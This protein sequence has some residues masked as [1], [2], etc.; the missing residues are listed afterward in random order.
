MGKFLVRLTIVFT[1][2]Y[3]V[4]AFLLAQFFGIDILSN[5]HSLLFELCVV[6]YTFSEGAFH[7]KYMRYCAVSVLICDALTQMDNAFN[8]LTIASH[9][10]IPISIL[11][12]GVGT[13]ATLAIRHFI[14][15]NKIK[16]QRYEQS[17]SNEKNSTIAS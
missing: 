8:F 6:V 1:V 15:V 3:F 17:I 5:W 2:L 12:L 11:A 7:C 13:S 14:R 10:L 4:V 9:N 16:K